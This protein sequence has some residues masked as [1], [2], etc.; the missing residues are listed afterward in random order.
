M[1]QL[2]YDKQPALG[3]VG[4][5]YNVCAE[6]DPALAVEPIEFGTKLSEDTLNSKTGVVTIGTKKVLLTLSGDLGASNV[7]SC[8]VKTYNPV[9]K[10]ETVTPITYT[11]LSSHA[12]SMTAIVNLI[13]LVTGI[14]STT[15]YTGDVITVLADTGYIV[16]ISSEGVAGGSAVTITKANSDNRVSA[17]FAQFIHKELFEENGAFVSRY[18][19]GD[20][21]NNM[22]EGRPIVATPTGFTKT[23]TLYYVGYGTNRGQ[24]SNVAGN[25]GIPVGNDVKAYMA[26]S[27]GKGVLAFE[28][29]NIG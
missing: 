22:R 17:G 11:Y 15:S 9:T 20:I 3:A 6:S 21:V 13:K 4:T 26:S 8:T 10:V 19:V 27:N 29:N 25:N 12:S 2:T 24:I 1:T 23:D 16:E 5:S 7:F 14:K 28:L 18:K